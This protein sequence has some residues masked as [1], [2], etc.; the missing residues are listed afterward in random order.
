[1]IRV[2]RVMQRPVLDTAVFKLLLVLEINPFLQTVFEKSAFEVHP[3][4]HLYN[5]IYENQE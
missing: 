5:P 1:M 3:K 2:P 4:C